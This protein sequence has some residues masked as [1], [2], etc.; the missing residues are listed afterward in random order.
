MLGMC[1]ECLYRYSKDDY[2]ELGGSAADWDYWNSEH[3]DKDFAEDFNIY[4]GPWVEWEETEGDFLEQSP[5]ATV[6]TIRTGN[7]NVV[8]EI[9][10]KDN[11]AV[12]DERIDEL[13]EKIR[14]IGGA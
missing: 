12:R 5:S 4:A 8:I 10:T 9:Y 6:R 3:P 2:I 13:V 1:N 14:A 7:P 11:G